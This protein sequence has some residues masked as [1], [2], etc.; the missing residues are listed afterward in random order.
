MDYICGIKKKEISKASYSRK[1]KNQTISL[2]NLKKFKKLLQI[3]R[4]VTFPNSVCEAKLRQ[5]EQERFIIC[6]YRC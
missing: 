4:N 3:R 6:E 1:A 5:A 2:T